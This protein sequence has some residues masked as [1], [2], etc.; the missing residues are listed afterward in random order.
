M[1]VVINA[2][3]LAKL[4]TK[5]KKMQNWLDYYQVKYSRNDSKRPTMKVL[6]LNLI[7]NLMSL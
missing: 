7:L 6:I 3:K 2:N 5:K 1:Q 4:V